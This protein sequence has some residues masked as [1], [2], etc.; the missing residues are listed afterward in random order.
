MHGG[1]ELRRAIPTASLE[2]LARA[3]AAVDSS[4]TSL[5][6]SVFEQRAEFVRLQLGQVSEI[7]REAVA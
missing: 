2:P 3:L 4:V 1:E 5:A 7:G 6:P